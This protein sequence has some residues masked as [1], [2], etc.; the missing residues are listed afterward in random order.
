MR[1]NLVKKNCF[2]FND[3]KGGCNICVELICGHKDCTLY[4]TRDEYQRQVAH[5]A[6]RLKQIAAAKR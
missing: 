4:K 6:E 5:C 1:T 2:A 3:E